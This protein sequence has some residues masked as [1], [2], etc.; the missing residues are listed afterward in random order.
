MYAWNCLKV[1]HV[2]VSIDHTFLPN[3]HALLTVAKTKSDF[4]SKVMD[5]DSGVARLSAD[6]QPFPPPNLF[7]R[8]QNERNSCFVLT[9]IG[10]LK[11]LQHHNQTEMSLVFHYR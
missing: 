1:Y 2:L 6:R 7:T 8:I 4:F 9:N 10:K 3:P 5:T 11:H